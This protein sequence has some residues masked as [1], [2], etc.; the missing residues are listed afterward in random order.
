MMRYIHVSHLRWVKAGFA[1]PLRSRAAGREHPR[2]IILD[3]RGRQSSRPC[4]SVSLV[5]VPVLSMRKTIVAARMIL[6][7]LA[8]AHAA[9]AGD[10][11]SGGGRPGG[12]RGTSRS[13]EMWLVIPQLSTVEMFPTS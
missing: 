4:G 7:D 13:F 2:L 1:D 5:C 9:T 11:Q 12:P 10:S 6:N 3:N 8:S